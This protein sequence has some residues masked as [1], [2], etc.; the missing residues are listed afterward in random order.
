MQRLCQGAALG[1]IAEVASCQSNA[2]TNYGLNTIINNIKKRKKIR[3][4]IHMN[5][6][7]AKTKA[8]SIYLKSGVPTHQT[9]PAKHLPKCTC[10]N[11]KHKKITRC[12][13]SENSKARR[14]IAI[15]DSDSVSCTFRFPT[16]ASASLRAWTNSPR[17]KRLLAE[18]STNS[19][20]SARMLTRK[21]TFSQPH[22]SLN[23]ICPLRSH[24]NWDGIVK[25]FWITWSTPG[26]YV[27][28]IPTMNTDSLFPDKVHTWTLPF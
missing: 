4:R 5:T 2:H 14:R 1:H 7:M 3:D 11:I 9:P 21:S 16:L 20:T 22:S 26:R 8:D 10:L 25:S 28:A 17:C 15:S 27:R 6:I 19:W 24:A 18:A 12:A 23:Y 13:L